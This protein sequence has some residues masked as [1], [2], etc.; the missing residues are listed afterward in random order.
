MSN[1]KLFVESCWLSISIPDRFSHP[2]DRNDPLW[3]SSKNDRKLCVRMESKV[4]HFYEYKNELNKNLISFKLINYALSWEF[5][6]TDICYLLLNGAK[7]KNF[8]TQKDWVRKSFENPCSG[9]FHTEKVVPK[10]SGSILSKILPKTSWQYSAWSS[11]AIN[12]LWKKI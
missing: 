10:T 7:K 8:G 3:R 11:Q 2:I 5:D 4:C 12:F 6:V 9:K 1:L